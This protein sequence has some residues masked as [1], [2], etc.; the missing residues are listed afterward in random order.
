MT[1][2][3]YAYSSDV[4]AKTGSVFIDNRAQSGFGGAIYCEASGRLTADEVTFKSNN[5][6]RG[7][8]VFLVSSGSESDLDDAGPVEVTRCVFETNE[9]ED[10]GGIYAASG[11]VAIN[12]STFVGNSGKLIKF[13]C[14]NAL[15]Q[16]S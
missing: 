6:I 14:T 16:G 13:P 15:I 7:G 8:A 3:I 12:S 1:G 9:A 4:E 10:G 2:A 5:A 11:Y